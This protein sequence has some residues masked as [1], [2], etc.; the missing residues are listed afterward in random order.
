[1]DEKNPVLK[2][3]RIYESYVEEEEIQII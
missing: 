3:F 1:M 2:S